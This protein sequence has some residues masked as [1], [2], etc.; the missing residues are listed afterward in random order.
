PSP[1]EPVAA[2]TVYPEKGI[3]R[4]H[5]GLAALHQRATDRLIGEELCCLYV[6]MTRARYAPE[7]IVQPDD[8]RRESTPSAAAVLRGA[9]APDQPAEPESELWRSE[10]FQGWAAEVETRRRA[11]HEAPEPR[12]IELRLRPGAAS[13]VPRWKRLSPSS[14]EGA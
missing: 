2:A 10:P 9:L 12:T 7:M 5:A 8:G 6:A 13:P 3:C 14:L 11:A 4:L 1:F